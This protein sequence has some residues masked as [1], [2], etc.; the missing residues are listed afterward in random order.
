ML[1]RLAGGAAT[2]PMFVLPLTG[3]RKPRPLLEGDR[4]ITAAAVSPNGKWLAYASGS[5]GRRDVYV[6][7]F[8]AAIGKWQISS[9]G[10]D[11]PVWRA[12]GKELF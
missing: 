4:A 7:S 11:N 5:S 3:E 6:T 9:E 2:G 12:D 10:S 8:P 1:Y